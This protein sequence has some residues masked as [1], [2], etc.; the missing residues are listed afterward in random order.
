MIGQIPPN[1]MFELFEKMI[2]LILSY[3][4]DI[5][6]LK[7]GSTDAL[8]KVFLCFVRC[9]LQ[10]KGTTSNVI[11]LAECGRVP[12]SVSCRDSTICFM[13]RLSNMPDTTLVKQVL[14]SLMNLHDQGFKTC[15]SL[16]LKVMRELDIDPSCS[17]I[18]NFKTDLG[19]KSSWYTTQ[20]HPENIQYVQST[21]CHGTLSL[22]SEKYKV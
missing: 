7:Q 18:E 9:V 11:S 8:A 19:K 12:P 4:S 1:M 2:T 21:L 10:I 17:P 22:P 16:V 5:L 15:V 3:G 13:N 14:N 6:G 20:P